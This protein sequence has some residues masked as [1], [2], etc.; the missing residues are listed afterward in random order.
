MYQSKEELIQFSGAL[1]SSAKK[2]LRQAVE[3][4]EAKLNLQDVP[5]EI[6]H[7]WVIVASTAPMR[8]VCYVAHRLGYSVFIKAWSVE[9]LAQRIRAFGN[10]SER[11]D[12]TP[13]DVF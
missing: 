13:A 9:E 6:G 11:M 1:R 3:A 5:T 8:G 2:A 12:A 7:P 4:V 10:P